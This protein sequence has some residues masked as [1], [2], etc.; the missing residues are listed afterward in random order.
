[1]KGTWNTSFIK[2]I[3]LTVFVSPECLCTTI[4]C[5]LYI[6]KALPFEEIAIFF[7]RDNTVV[8]AVTLIAPVAITGISVRCFLNLLQPEENNKI[9][10]NWADYENYKLTS[11]IGLMYCA[12]PIVPTIISWIF[13]DIYSE[14]DV[15]FFYCLLNILSI[16][17]LI[18][19]FVAQNN[20]KYYL[21]KYS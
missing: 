16:I 14:Y 3:L 1:M 4:F 7:F 10:Y 13:F 9:L 21:Q 11:Y 20:V 19:M 2:K 5:F 8:V 6:S 18:T 15:G 12:F 17:S